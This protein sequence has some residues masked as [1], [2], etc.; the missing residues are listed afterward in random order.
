MRREQIS[1]FYDTLEYIV[2]VGLPTTLGLN[3]I[4]LQVLFQVVGPLPILFDFFD[5]LLDFVS[6]RMLLYD[7]TKLFFACVERLG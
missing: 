4:C 6:P 2:L 7:F 3:L 1:E 5:F